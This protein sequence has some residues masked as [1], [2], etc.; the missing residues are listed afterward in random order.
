[1]D[2][3]NDL[4]HQALAEAI[5]GLRKSSRAMH[6]F[7][8]L[9]KASEVLEKQNNQSLF[10]DYG[11]CLV[12]QKWLMQNPDGSYPP[13]QVVELVFDVLEKLP[14]TIDHLQER[15]VARVI[16]QYACDRPQFG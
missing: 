16:Q 14:I 3:A 7:Q 4:D 10:L 9:A 11:G 8:M 15:E 6:R 5:Q 12:L 1:M 13:F 2:S